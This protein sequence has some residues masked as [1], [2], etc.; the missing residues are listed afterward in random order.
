[1]FKGAKDYDASF[2][3]GQLVGWYK[4]TVDK[5][6]A[7]LSAERRGTLTTPDLEGFMFSNNPGNK[8]PKKSKKKGTD[9]DTDEIL[10]SKVRGTPTTKAPE[11]NVSG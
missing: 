4:Q 2:I 5:P 6:N 1:M 11:K 9:S 10:P 8:P 3:W 7:S